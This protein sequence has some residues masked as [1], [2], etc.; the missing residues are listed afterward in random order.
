MNADLR[1]DDIES[2]EL[3]EL[4]H[5]VEP[6]QDDEARDSTSAYLNEIGLVPLL[7][8][9][10]ELRLA[11]R[12][13]AGD[14]DARR[15]M[16][17]ANLRLVV[18]IARGYVGRGV[19]LL[20]L[21]AEG[22]LGLIRAVEKFD[23]SRRLRFS[24]YATWWIRD[25]VQ[26]ALMS[27]GRTVRLPVHVLREFAQ[28]LRARRQLT[29]ELGRMPGIDELAR[30]LGRS[31]ADIAGLF[32]LTDRISSLDAPLSAS[33][34]RA[35]IEQLVVDDAGAAM[36]RA[37]AGEP[38]DSRIEHCLAR[39]S[40]RQRLVLQRRYGLNDHATQTLAEI[41]AELGLTRERVR[42]IQSEALLRLRGLVESENADRGDGD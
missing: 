2:D 21:I 11:E 34:D 3:L 14:A 40:E 35:L 18:S 25:G 41:A 17:E 36:A 20:D 42:Q 27:Q 13:A 26:H 9:D 4:V 37:H 5:A 6:Q 33:D 8:A 30:H 23:A 16:I 38:R 7:D 1:A 39:L 32:T 31:G 19:P 24:T 15:R 22:N 29:H 10:D 28:V 12:V